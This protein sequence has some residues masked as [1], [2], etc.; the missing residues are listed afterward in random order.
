MIQ[1][2]SY[3]LKILLALD[4]LLAV[5]IYNAYD[6]ETVSCF[7]GRTMHGSWQESVID[8]VFARI[9]GEKNHC[10]NNVEA[11]FVTDEMAAVPRGDAD[12]H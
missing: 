11:R 6:E 3:I 10:L 12:A 5:L 1:D 9:T 2:K 4:R 8:W 7:V